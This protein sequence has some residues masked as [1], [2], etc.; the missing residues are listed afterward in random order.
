MSEENTSSAKVELCCIVNP[1]YVCEA[2][3]FCECA[4]HWKASEN[5][6]K[7]H[8]SEYRMVNGVSAG[9]C[10]VKNV[11]VYSTRTRPNRWAVKNPSE[12][13]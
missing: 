11:L 10:S 1:C 13:I 9:M 5:A 2:C 6:C 3:G 8:Y 12:E 7:Y 4:E